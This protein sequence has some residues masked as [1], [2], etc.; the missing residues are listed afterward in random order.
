MVAIASACW[1][2][3]HYG[4]LFFSQPLNFFVEGLF[5]G[6]P[7]ALKGSG[8]SLS[9]LAGLLGP[10]AAAPLGSAA[11]RPPYSSLSHQPTAVAAAPPLDPKRGLHVQNMQPPPLC[12]WPKQFAYGS[13][14]WSFSSCMGVG[15]IL[16]CI[17]WASSQD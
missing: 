4:R 16:I 10:A 15:P 12:A 6:L 17:F 8:R 3:N 7:L 1:S 5:L 9:G 11:S 2:N 14:L 13:W